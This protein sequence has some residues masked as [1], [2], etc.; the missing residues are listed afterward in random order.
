MT[1]NVPALPLCALQPVYPGAIVDPPRIRNRNTQSSL[2]QTKVRKNTGGEEVF[3]QL[4]TNRL[5]VFCAPIGP[6]A[7]ETSSRYNDT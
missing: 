2:N 7:S 3:A 1:L 4:P 5:T 6:T